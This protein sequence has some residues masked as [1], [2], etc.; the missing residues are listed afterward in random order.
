MLAPPSPATIP[1]KICNTTEIAQT[2][3]TTISMVTSARYI[4]CLRCHIIVNYQLSTINFLIVFVLVVVYVI[5]RVVPVD[6]IVEKFL[7]SNKGRLGEFL[8]IAADL[9]LLTIF[10]NFLKG[11][12][13]VGELG[14]FLAE[15]L[16]DV[17]RNLVGTFAEDS[18]AFIDIVCALTEVHDVACNGVCRS[19]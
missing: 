1:P 4:V 14:E 6:L 11:V 16:L 18:Y 12:I 13:V 9:Y 7:C 10:K 19:F 15:L 8:V 3:A 17:L 5:S 2:L